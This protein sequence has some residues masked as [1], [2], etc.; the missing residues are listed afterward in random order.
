MMLDLLPTGDGYR[1]VAEMRKADLP[2]DAEASP[3]QRAVM[4]M[5]MQSIDP[6]WALGVSFSGTRIEN[7][8]G[9]LSADGRTVTWKIPVMQFVTVSAE[10]RSIV[11]KADIYFK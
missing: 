10:N 2:L 11:L 3:Q 8:N 1:F 9:T 4:L 5:M 7:T 6:K